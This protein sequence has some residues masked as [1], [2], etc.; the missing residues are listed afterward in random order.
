MDSDYNNNSNSNSSHSAESQHG[1]LLQ[2]PVSTQQVS[3]VSSRTR[4]PSKDYD[5]GT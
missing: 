2:R 4:A 1:S 3:N 5:K